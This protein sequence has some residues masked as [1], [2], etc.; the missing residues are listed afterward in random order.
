MDAARTQEIE[1]NFQAFQREVG[2]LIPAKEGKF[3]LLHAEAIEEVFDTLSDAILAGH[4][5]YSNGMFSIQQVS[6][7]AMDL[8]FFSHANPQGSLRQG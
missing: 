5:K 1:R 7:G 3:A 8:G 6:A 2:N 4:R